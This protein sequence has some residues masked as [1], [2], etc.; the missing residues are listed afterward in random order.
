MILEVAASLCYQAPPLSITGTRD[1]PPFRL[2]VI[3]HEGDEGDGGGSSACFRWGGGR[4]RQP[5]CLREGNSKH[6]KWGVGNRAGSRGDAQQ[7]HHE[8]CRCE[9]REVPRA[10]V[11]LVVYPRVWAHAFSRG[12]RFSFFQKH[13]QLLILRAPTI[14]PIKSV[15][16]ER[17]LAWF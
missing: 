15:S 5:I 1:T 11:F 8:R 9:R 6:P 13:M 3:E 14:F 17:F 4:V 16:T 12:V 2:R 10:C 7:A